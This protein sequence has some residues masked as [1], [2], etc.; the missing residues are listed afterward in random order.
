MQPKR[1]HRRTFNEPGHAHALTFS[2]YHGY[3]FLAA[4]RT[5]R[6]LASAIDA[7]RK[8]FD[9]QLWAYV[10]M[11]DHAHL[12]VFPRRREYDIAVVRNAIKSP[13]AK[14]AIRYLEERAPDWIPR[15]TRRRGQKIERVFWQSGGGYDRNLVEP[16]TLVTT[17]EYIHLN[18]VRRG[19]ANSA[20]DWKWSSA[21]WFAGK[22]DGPLLPDPIPPDWLD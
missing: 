18:P 14:R 10:F 19:L 2:C 21:G 15:I 3:H 12:L 13:V 4:E 5:R 11:P 1:R 22:G 9:F 20:S 16:G 17:I 6:W 8:R 7:A